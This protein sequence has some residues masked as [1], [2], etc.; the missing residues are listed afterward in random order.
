MII[1]TLI[2]FFSFILNIDIARYKEDPSYLIDLIK[3]IILNN[4]FLFIVLFLLFLLTIYLT[5]SAIMNFINKNKFSEAFNFKTVF[6]K[7]FTGKYLE[8]SIVMFIYAFLVYFLLNFIPF[9]GGIIASFLV[10][11]TLY[12]AYGA[13]Y[14]K[15]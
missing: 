13:I 2:L 4:L 14:N 12:S 6:G 3:P 1:L 5:P 7:A 8:I 11:V 15:L 10:Q 9:I